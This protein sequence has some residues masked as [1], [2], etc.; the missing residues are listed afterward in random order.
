MSLKNPPSPLYDAITSDE[1]FDSFMDVALAAE[2]ED[3]CTVSNPETSVAVAEQ[4]EEVL[5]PLP[6]LLKQGESLYETIATAENSSNDEGTVLEYVVLSKDKVDTETSEET[7]SNTIVTVTASPI[8]KS[9][10]PDYPGAINDV[11]SKGNLEDQTVVKNN[12]PDLNDLYAVVDK[13][14]KNKKCIVTDVETIEIT[15]N[16]GYAKI[17]KKTQ[18][19]SNEQNHDLYAVVDKTHKVDNGSK[20]N[21]DSSNDDYESIISVSKSLHDITSKN[22][23]GDYAVVDYVID[24]KNNSEIVNLDYQSVSDL[25]LEKRINLRPEDIAFGLRRFQTEG[26]A[27]LYKSCLNTIERG[28]QLTSVEKKKSFFNFGRTKRFVCYKLF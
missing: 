17:G 4:Q 27:D 24:E 6:L 18:S 5:M 7:C 16:G 2:K 10:L 13:S 23:E 8:K 15:S 12:Q 19:D 26:Q 9:P 20:S 25:K 11:K 22:K 21:S 28:A 3:L 14:Q 1:L